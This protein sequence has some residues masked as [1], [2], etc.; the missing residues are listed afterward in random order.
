MSFPPGFNVI[1][2]FVGSCCGLTAL[3]L[4]YFLS[5]NDQTTDGFV[6]IL[7]GPEQATSAVKIFSLLEL[8]PTQCVMV[9]E[10]LPSFRNIRKMKLS[11]SAE[12][13]PL[14]EVTV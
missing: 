5:G 1:G 3:V 12:S 14:N 7:L 2:K 4:W 6:A 8:T 13:A 11:L 9:T 10:H